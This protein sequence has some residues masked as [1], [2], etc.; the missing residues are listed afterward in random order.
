MQKV[1]DV[2]ADVGETG[3]FHWYPLQD[4]GVGGTRVDSDLEGLSLESDFMIDDR[5]MTLA[6]RVL[7]SIRD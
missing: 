2:R 3:E 5:L 7:V 1:E 4:G 6:P